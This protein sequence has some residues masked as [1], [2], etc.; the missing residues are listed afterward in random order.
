MVD[1]GMLFG[2]AMKA[3]A[4]TALFGCVLMR[5]LANRPYAIAPYMAQNAFIAHSDWDDGI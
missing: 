3:R 4:L 2:P 5:L 1:A